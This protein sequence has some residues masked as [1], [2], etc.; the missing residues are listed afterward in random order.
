MLQQKNEIS[1]LSPVRSDTSRIDT[2]KN[3]ANWLHH[4]GQFEHHGRPQRLAN[5]AAP[6]FGYGKLAK[7]RHVERAVIRRN[8]DERE[9]E[10]L[11]QQVAAE[12]IKVIVLDLRV[13]HNQAGHAALEGVA[14][15]LEIHNAVR[16]NAYLSQRVTHVGTDL[17]AG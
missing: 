1:Y 10:H 5:I 17:Q 14:G 8:L 9:L 16:R 15:L 13:H 6:D 12:G 2:R 4:L 3:S 11:A 7:A